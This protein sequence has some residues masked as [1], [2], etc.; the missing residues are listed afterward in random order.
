MGVAE[1]AIRDWM[2][3]NHRKYWESLIG[4]RQA[5]GLIQRPSAKRAKE[6]LKLNRK[7]LVGGRTIDR[8]LSPEGTSLKIG[9]DSP[10]CERCQEKDK[11]AT[12]PVQM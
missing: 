4:L 8:T 3:M 5:K 7:Q 9:T 10:T 1:K 6:L 12:R 2:T 11:T